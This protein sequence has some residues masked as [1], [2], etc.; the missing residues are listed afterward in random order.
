MQH[1]FSLKTQLVNMHFVYKHKYE[2][3]ILYTNTT[4][5]HIFF[6]LTQLC[7]IYFLYKLNYATCILYKNTPT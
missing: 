7:N 4:V 1:I 5:Q 2:T 6:I 3:Y